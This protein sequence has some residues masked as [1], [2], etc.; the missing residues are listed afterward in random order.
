MNSSRIAAAAVLLLMVFGAASAQGLVSRYVAGEHYVQ[1]E[2]PVAQPNDGKIHVVEFFL[3]SCPHCYHLEPEL[4]DWRE[5]LG[6]DVVFSRVP[7]L[8]GAGGERYARLYYTAEAL[9]VLETVHERI[10][11]AIHQ[12]GKRLLSE[13]AMREFMESEGVDPERF[14]QLFESDEISAKVREAG[15]TM[16]AYQVRATPSLGVAGQYYVSGRTAGSN[17]RMFD[18]ADYLIRQQRARQDD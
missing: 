18:V 17:D 5:D 8:F 3:Y 2:N 4:N 15:E 9:G 12:D 11:D 10:F 6:G 13:S 1:A 14:S 16:R 7:V